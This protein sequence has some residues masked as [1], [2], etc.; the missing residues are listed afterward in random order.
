MAELV[1]ERTKLELKEV[2]LNKVK[3]ELETVKEEYQKKIVEQ[4]NKKLKYLFFT[5]I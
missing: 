2:E 3:K 4:K 5:L 1:Q